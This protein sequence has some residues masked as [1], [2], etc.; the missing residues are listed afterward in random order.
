MRVGWAQQLHARSGCAV[1]NNCISATSAATAAATAAAAAAAAAPAAAPAA[2]ST[3][4]RASRLVGAG[5]TVVK[6]HAQLGDALASR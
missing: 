1:F 5:R 3:A 4:D 6:G 2:T